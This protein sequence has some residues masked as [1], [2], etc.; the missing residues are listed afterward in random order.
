MANRLCEWRSQMLRDRNIED[1]DGRPLYAYRLTVNEFN[2]LENLLQSSLAQFKS[3]LSSLGI[4]SLELSAE[5]ASGF[6]SLFVLYCAEWW[7][8]RYDGSGF[9]W[10]PILHDLGCQADEWSPSRRSACVSHGLHNWSLSLRDSVG[11]RYIGSI[12]LQGGLP[13][14]LLADARGALGRLLRCVLKE[15]VKAQVTSLEIQAWVRSLDHYLPRTYRQAE[16]F[17]LLTGVI[18]T[19]L[20]LKLQAGLVQST[21]AIEE[22][23]RRIPTWRDRFPLPV[24]DAE[25]QGL[26]EQ[27]V[28]DAASEKEQ[29]HPRL[30][31]VERSIER[32]EAGIWQLRSALPL[33]DEIDSEALAR[34]FFRDAIELRRFLDKLPRILHLTLQAADGE[35]AASLRK[36]AGQNKYRVERRP[37]NFSADCAAAEHT[38]HLTTTDGRGWAS[39][40]P[41][42]EELDEELPWVF[43]GRDEAPKLLKQ[44]GGT[45]AT[46]EAFVALP[47]GWQPVAADFERITAN[48]LLPN[49]GRQI[50]RVCAEV[51]FFLNSELTCRIRTGRAD[52]C[53]ESYEWRGQRLWQMAV[54]PAMAFLGKPRLYRIDESG[55]ASAI[56]GE[57][58]WRSLGTPSSTL[59]EPLGPT[60]M[61]HFVSGEVRGR[62]RMLILP[63]LAQVR[64]EPGDATSGS[65]R[66][67]HW[68]AASLHVNTMNITAVLHRDGNDLVADLKVGG[69]EPAPEWIEVDIHWPH[70]THPARLRLPFPVR[71]TRIFASGREL[72]PGALLATNQLSGI[73]LLCLGGNPS[74]FPR[75]CLRL[76]LVGKPDMIDIPIMMSNNS[77]HVEIRLQDYATEVAH[78]LANDDRPDANVEVSALIGNE[79][80]ACLQIGRYA[81]R[82][83]RSECCILIKAGDNEN[84]NPEELKG[85]SVLTLRLDS[86]GDEP[87]MLAPAPSE[88]P[89]QMAWAFC[90]EDREPG[91]WLV[92]PAADSQLVFR[93]TLWTIDGEKTDMGRLTTAIGISDPGQRE[94]ALDEVID[95]LGSDFLDP[96]WGDVERLAHQLGH[97]PL[98][99]LDLWRH[100]ARSDKAMAALAL[101]F[102]SFPFSF[103]D[104]FAAELPFAWE[105]VSF[106]AWKGAILNLQLQCKSC[107]ESVFQIVFNDHLKNR[108]DEITSRRPALRWSVALARTAALGEQS[109]ELLF[110]Q[111]ISGDEIS[112]LLFSGDESPW[113]RLL[114]SH[115]EDQWPESF[116]AYIAQARLDGTYKGFLCPN[117]QGYRESIT[118]LPI[119]LAAQMST[120]ASRKWLKHPDLIHALRKHIDF[121]PDWFEEAYNWSTARCVA[122][123][124]LKSEFT[125]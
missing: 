81:C 111:K 76:R 67:V 61:W 90:P 114:R 68:G 36:L 87:Q 15:A 19:I 78:L 2:S 30:F 113:Q 94:E 38:I 4:S 20:N 35:Q 51:R 65:I 17:V 107:F 71:G 12:A 56:T 8:R 47:P 79:S 89:R 52:A 74:T 26:I 9:T 86:P 63:S 101:R 105:T 121:D 70:T 82:L 13:M 73:R 49:F 85:L 54:R 33:P 91:S 123:G 31:W 124:L 119:L 32:D 23:D 22:L 1:A 69:H 7:R 48:G 115:A 103:I 37:W 44:G 21:G 72:A 28:K 62:A 59:R 6:P 55:G 10:D 109:Q 96:G 60:E 75:M 39:S 40:A 92:Y 77:M 98:V 80:Y 42:G 88:D 116:K 53:E 3:G 104:R 83:E 50:F 110:F 16:I 41:G 95:L 45:V 117:S 18:T 46:N 57:A 34:A 93:P 100:F 125:Q 118:N 66:L 112:R 25:A 29:R 11:L 27:L 24:E 99:T 120:G 58:R 108:L 102:S 84:L 43:D 64:L 122:A 106:T 97:L 14:R 5:H